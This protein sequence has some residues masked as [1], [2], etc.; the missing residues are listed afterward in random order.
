MIYS[1]VFLIAWGS[2]LKAL[3]TLRVNIF[4]IVL[5]KVVFKSCIIRVL[6]QRSLFNIHDGRPM[7]PSIPYIIWK[8][9]NLR[10]GKQTSVRRKVTLCDQA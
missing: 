8:L 6:N 2:A 4:L 7:W 3:N 9:L 5:W 1:S 10:L